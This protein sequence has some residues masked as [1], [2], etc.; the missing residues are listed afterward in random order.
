LPVF[1]F[2]LIGMIETGRYVRMAILA[3][4]AARAGVQYGAQSVFTA[5]DTV[6][7]SNAAVQ[8]GQNLS[9]WQVT[10]NHFCTNNGAIATCP[11]G[12]PS[13]TTAYYVQVVVTGTFTSLLKYPGIQNS[14]LITSTAVM[15]V[16]SQ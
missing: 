2:L 1:M 7:I 3:S 6:G 11:A 16:G 15:R 8:D 14:E 10:S 12:E 13:S 9:N 4:H 5:I